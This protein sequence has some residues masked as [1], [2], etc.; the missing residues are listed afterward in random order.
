MP[1]TA[2]KWHFEYLSLPAFY[3]VAAGA[4]SFSALINGAPTPTQVP[5]DASVNELGLP[6]EDI[7]IDC[8]GYMILNNITRSNTRKIDYCDHAANIIHTYPSADDWA[9]NDVIKLQDPTINTPGYFAIDLS[10]EI[11]SNAVAI[12]FVV[13]LVDSNRLMQSTVH[14]I[15]SYNELTK[16]IVFCLQVADREVHYH[17][18][19]RCIN[20]KIGLMFGLVTE[21]EIFIKIL[22]YLTEVEMATKEEIRAEMDDNSTK[23]GLVP[24]MDTNI[25][26]IEVAID[27]LNCATVAGLSS[28]DAA[29]N[30]KLEQLKVL[31]D[32]I[33][34]MR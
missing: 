17:G 2:T 23:L 20:Q 25:D 26:D 30:A 15:S 27:A 33:Q 18:L 1:E 7:L 34:H 4:S 10:A 12:Y 32:D 22:G 9:D 5:Y 11:P 8:F 6:E 21:C 16:A 13:S 14:P 28:H 19:V 31:I 3:I 29:V 24:G